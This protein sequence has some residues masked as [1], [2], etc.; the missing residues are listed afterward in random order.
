M[1]DSD[2]RVFTSSIS[3]AMLGKENVNFANESSVDF[4]SSHISLLVLSNGV[5]KWPD[6][7]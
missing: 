1:E 2:C 4:C 6:Q 5:G 7:C 3:A